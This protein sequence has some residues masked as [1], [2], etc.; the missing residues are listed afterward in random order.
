MTS[1]LRYAVVGTGNIGGILAQRFSD[2]RVPALLAN[3]RG[4]ETIDVS[5]LSDAITPVALDAAL[6]ADVIIL[7][8]PFL[9]VREL[10]KMRSDWSGKIIIDTTNAFLVPGAEEILGG[11]LSTDFNAETFPAPRSSRRS[12]KPPPRCSP[13]SA[14]LSSGDAWCSCP[15]TTPRQARW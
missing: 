14:H 10:G 4:P 13:R 6:D 1:G 8:I 11:R 3:T 12:T 15:V 7:S 9:Q 2:H 5:E